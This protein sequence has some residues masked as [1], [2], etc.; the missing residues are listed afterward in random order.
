[1]TA[2]RLFNRSVLL[3]VRLQNSRT[4]ERIFIKFDTGEFLPRTVRAFVV[5]LV[6]IFLPTTLH[7][8]IHAL[9]SNLAQLINKPAGIRWQI[10]AYI[11]SHRNI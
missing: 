3:S 11:K 4:G 9:L 10:T 8:D 1:M 7:D 5:L 6:Q 2:M